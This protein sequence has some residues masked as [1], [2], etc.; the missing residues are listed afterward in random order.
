M[1]DSHHE[2][3]IIPNLDESDLFPFMKA[4]E[5]GA[6][7]IM[8]AHIIYPQYDDNIIATLSKT[9]LKKSAQRKDGLS[10]TNHN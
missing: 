9:I 6:E 7:A 8:T 10:R 4:I 5:A 1:Q 3:P 2:I